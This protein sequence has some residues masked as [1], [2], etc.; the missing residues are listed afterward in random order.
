MENDK[1]HQKLMINIEIRVHSSF[2]QNLLEG[3]ERPYN[4]YVLFLFLRMPKSMTFKINSRFYNTVL[5]KLCYL[6]T[7]FDL[8]QSN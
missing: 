1:I 2:V 6:L 3:N 5:N 8:G 7:G 4:Y